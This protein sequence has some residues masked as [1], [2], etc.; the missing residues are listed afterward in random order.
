MSHS[1]PLILNV[2]DH[3]AS[4]YAVT[5]ILRCAGFQV[6]EGATGAEALR[7]A[8]EQRPDL[9]VL[10]V[11][12]P[13]L[14]GLE[15]CRR[16]KA[17]PHL[18]GM[19]VLLLSARYTRPENK[20]EGLDSGAD[21]YLTQ[22][23]GSAELL[24][25]VR[26]LLRMRQAEEALRQ[27]AEELAEADRRKDEFLA[28]LAHE[29]RNPL[30]AMVNA[31]H[32]A[33]ST[34]PAEVSPRALEVLGRQ[35][36]HMTRLVEDLLDMS[37]L[38]QGRIELRREPVDLRQVVRHSEQARRELIEARGLSLEVRL[39]AKGSLW[40]RGDATRLEQVLSNLLDNASKYTEPGGHIELEVEVEPGAAGPQAALR[41]RDTG[42]GMSPEL[43][44]RA[45]ELFVQGEQQIDRSRGGLGIGLTLVRRLVELHGGSVSVRSEG[46]GRGSEFTVRLPL[47]EQPVE[48]RVQA[49]RVPARPERGGRRVL[50][51]EDNED[52]R[53]VLRELLEVW[54]HQV[55]EAADGL[56]GVE[57]F[58][59]V[60]PDVA[61]VDLGLP[62]MDGFQ[63]ARAI[64]QSEGGESVLL[65][66]LTG[67]SGEYRA[68]AL[69][70]G[71]DLHLV[72]PVVP[73]EL[74]R[75]LEQLPERAACSAPVM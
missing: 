30:A 8:A 73:E 1:P 22:P 24:A 58:R 47:Q 17:D 44:G 59:Q 63:V 28:M 70:A 9:A 64:R 32:L 51:V 19:A 11:K 49:P 74:E 13:D 35:S 6:V 45:F 16:L 10:D 12:L 14:S 54:G 5:R 46:P 36:R 71:F 50:L 15:V 33:E 55:V 23:V 42:I 18:A 25:T 68:R 61:L 72:K 21:G 3:D 66:A 62:E 38:N 67:Y 7:L 75:L 31:L 26:A 57:R 40:L 41:V 69:A 20:V 29:L 53:E 39:P 4:R 34:W 43:M 60:R 48:P 56:E 52:T 2:N 27:R 37:R 65:V